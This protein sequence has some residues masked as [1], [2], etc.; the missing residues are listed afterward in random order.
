MTIWDRLILDRALKHTVETEKKRKRDR[1]PAAS[2]VDDFLKKI[3]A[4]P[5]GVAGPGKDDSPKHG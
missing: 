3:G 1:A 4:A 2:S 5:D